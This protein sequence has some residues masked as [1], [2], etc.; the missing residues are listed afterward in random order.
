LNFKINT[1]VWFIFCLVFLGILSLFIFLYVIIPYRTRKR[2]IKR[3]HTRLNKKLQN[4][5]RLEKKHTEDKIKG[6]ENSNN[7]LKV[8]LKNDLNNLLRSN[9]P[10]DLESFFSNFEKLYPDFKVSLFRISQN[11]TANEIKLAAFLRLNLSSKEI[12]KLLSVHPDSVNKARY[13]LRKK[14]N[15]SSKE[16]LSTYILNI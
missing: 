12:S 16:D 7:K 9:E 15:L 2:N 8:S 14:L 4:F 3:R 1:D 10:V 13:R 6:L 11:L 5:E